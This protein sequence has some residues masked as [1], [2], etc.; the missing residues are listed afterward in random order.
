MRSRVRVR[1]RMT[2]IS[3]PLEYLVSEIVETW[4][5]EPLKGVAQIV[6]KFQLYTR[7]GIA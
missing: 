2:H 5:F 3:P 7:S 4:E 1:L 6:G